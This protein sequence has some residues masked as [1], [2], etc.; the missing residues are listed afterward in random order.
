MERRELLSV[1]ERCVDRR[2]NS[3]DEMHKCM[4]IIA[5]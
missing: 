3:V 2:E 4:E 1:E 5:V